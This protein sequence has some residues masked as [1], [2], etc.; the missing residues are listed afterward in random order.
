MAMV[1]TQAQSISNYLHYVLR[2][3]SLNNEQKRQATQGIINIIDPLLVQLGGT[4][5][6]DPL[7][8]N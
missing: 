6:N 7:T 3:Y 5:I 4:P 2:N 1:R 8:S